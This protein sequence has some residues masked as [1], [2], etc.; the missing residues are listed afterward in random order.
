MGASWIAD[1]LVH[2]AL[3]AQIADLEEYEL[4]VPEEGSYRSEGLRLAFLDWGAV[5][6]RPIIFLH[7]GCLTAR[8]W[9]MVCLALREDNRC[10]ALDQRGHGKS[11]WSPDG[12]YGAPAHVRDLDRLLEHLEIERPVLI[13]QSLGGL[14]A[15]AYAA[16][17]PDK[18]GG[19]VVIDTGPGVSR[20]GTAPIVD[21]VSQPAA[22]DSIDDFVDRAMNFNSRR[23]RR[24]L[25]LSLSHNLRVLPNGKLTWKW[26]PELL[27][28]KSFELLTAQI[29]RM[30]GDAALVECLALVIRGAESKVLSR[31]A[32]VELAEMM[33]HG[34]WAEVPGAAH[35]VQGDNPRGLAEVLRPFLDRL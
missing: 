19:L 6:R 29:P 12:D 25:R 32:A 26:D 21:F 7:G 2:L 20:R 34:R 24:L 8:T 13:G 11:S 17:F 1:Q 3:A 16:R 14:N 35:N 15:L 18:V 22:L 9:D 31:A 28:P 4:A 30:R 27:S 5:A 33:P 23:D 10:V